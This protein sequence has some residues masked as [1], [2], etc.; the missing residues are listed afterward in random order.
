MEEKPNRKDINYEIRFYEGILKKNPE[1]IEAM[2]ALA[3]LYTKG[4]FF[5]E[6]L[7][8]DQKL[9]LLKPDDP[10][11]YY[12]LACSYSLLNDVD[13]SF[14][15]M[16]KAISLGYDDFVYLEEDDDL[17]NLRKDSRFKKYFSK[18]KKKKPSR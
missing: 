7:R 18:V 13:S 5:S 17:S 1:F 4:E 3:D 15:A 2:I 11:V 10:L 6:G 12:N 16:K 14:S 8:I 9:A